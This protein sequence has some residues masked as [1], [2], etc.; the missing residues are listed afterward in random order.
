MFLEIIIAHFLAILGHTLCNHEDTAWFVN[1]T[2]NFAYI[3]SED[4]VM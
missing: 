4:N 2:N 1:P 3:L